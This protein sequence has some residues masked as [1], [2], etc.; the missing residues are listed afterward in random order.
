[1]PAAL[2]HNDIGKRGERLETHGALSLN[3]VGCSATLALASRHQLVIVDIA[4]AIFTTAV[5]AAAAATTTATTT[6]AA[7]AAP[8]ATAATDS[9]ILIDICSCSNFS[10]AARQTHQ[11]KQT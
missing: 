7:A 10:I 3:D 6:T 5:I 2:E 4:V 8:T 1:M 9:S 11:E